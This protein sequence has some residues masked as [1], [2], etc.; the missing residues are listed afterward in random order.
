MILVLENG[1]SLPCVY[2]YFYFFVEMEF[3][4]FA[5]ADGVITSSCL[6]SICIFVSISMLFGPNTT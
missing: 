4:F 3:G 6:G 5:V 2:F 1:S